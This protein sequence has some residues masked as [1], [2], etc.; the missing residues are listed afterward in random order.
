M[1]APVYTLV[2]DVSQLNVVGLLLPL[3]GLYC[4]RQAFNPNN[5]TM[6]MFM[7]GGP[8]KR[9]LYSLIFA[10]FSL[11][12]VVYTTPVAYRNVMT[13]MAVKGVEDG[14][15]LPVA[16]GIASKVE[17]NGFCI[18][19]VCLGYEGNISGLADG[20]PVRAEYLG[21]QLIRL[22]TGSNP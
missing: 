21:K 18:D 11:G 16:T 13:Y 9:L 3:F 14:G 20:V 1:A 15:A 8:A 7:I 19:D 5:K 6:Q 22:E 12:L 4:I 2:Y 17:A 10:A